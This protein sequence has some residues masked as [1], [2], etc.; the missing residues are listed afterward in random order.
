MTTPKPADTFTLVRPH[1]KTA[2]YWKDA[3]ITYAEL[4]GHSLAVAARYPMAAGA[5]AVIYSENRPEWLAALHGIWRNHAIAVPVDSMA[6]ASELAY[7]IGDTE[8]EIVFCSDK[9]RLAS[10]RP[11]L[12]STA[13]NRA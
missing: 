5:R 9:T 2:L 8:P 13:R 12:A 7:I 1:P 11:W 10:S 3:R 4:L 6:P